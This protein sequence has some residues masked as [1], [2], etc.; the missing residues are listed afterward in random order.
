MSRHHTDIPSVATRSQIYFANSGRISPSTSCLATRKSALPHQLL[1]SEHP[2]SG[3]DLGWA[4]STVAVRI[5]QQLHES[6]ILMELH[7]AVEERQTGIICHESYGG[8]SPAS[9]ADN[10][11]HQPGHRFPTD[12]DDLERVAVQVQWV[13]VTGAL[14]VEE[15]FV[16]LP[17]LQ[18]QLF[19]I[20]KTLA[21]DRPAIEVDFVPWNFFKLHLEGVIRF[22]RS[23]AAPKH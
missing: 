18:T 19:D 9:Y 4:P 12:F 2:G 7:V 11:L 8:G 20:R 14:V 6:E 3:C 22:G 21:I 16:A 1:S 5:L 13:D 23:A 15:E 17:F 10:V